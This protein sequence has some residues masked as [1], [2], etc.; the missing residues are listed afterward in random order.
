MTPVAP[1]AEP[2]VETIAKI[3]KATLGWEDHGIFTCMLD[4][5][6][7]A[8]GQGAGGYAL[9]EPVHVD[10]EF[11]GR[12]GTA[13]GMNWIIRLMRAVGVN[14]WSELQGRTVL[15]VIENR[16]VVGIKPL[17]T[18]NGEAFMFSSLEDSQ[19]HTH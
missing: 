13:Y 5:D 3:R 1:H 7:G 17:P 11:V 4:L 19:S 6:Y 9:D 2:R 16:R 14:D 15:A 10:G 12:V 18:E 8:I